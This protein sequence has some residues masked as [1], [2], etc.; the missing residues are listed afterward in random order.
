MK[1]TNYDDINL[2]QL[3][4]LSKSI[5]HP[6]RLLILK[7]LAE[8]G[9]WIEGEIV[10]IPDVAPTTV[11]QHLRE[12]KRVGLIKGRIFGAQCKYGINEEVLS[13]FQKLWQEMME[14]IHP[15]KSTS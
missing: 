11:I 14:N 7:A 4:T 3:A 6:A 13:L 12:L 10:G 1:R 5:G 2:Q 15:P 8:K 9:G